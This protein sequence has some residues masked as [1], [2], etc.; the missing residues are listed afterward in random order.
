[1]RQERECSDENSFKQTGQ[2][3]QRNREKIRDKPAIPSNSH[4]RPSL[5]RRKNL[6]AGQ[7]QAKGE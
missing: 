5:R 3:K 4:L 2:T 7:P 1:M 6:R